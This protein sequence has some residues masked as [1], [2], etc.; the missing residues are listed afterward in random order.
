MESWLTQIT[1]YL[2]V[3]SWQIAVLTIL[4]AITSFL[5]RNRSAHVRYLLWLIVLAKCLVPPFYSVPL[6]VLPYEKSTVVVPMSPIVERTAEDKASGFTM[7]ES[8]TSKVIPS[9]A[10]SSPKATKRLPTNNIRA[11][12]AIGWFIGVGVLLFFNVLNALR[13]QAWLWRQ[14]RVLPVKVRSHIEIFFSAQGLKR[15]PNIWLL[16]GINQPFVWGLVRGSIYLPINFTNFRNRNR[17][18]NLLGHEISHIMRLDALVNSLQ[19]IAQM[20][21]WFHPFVW[22]ANRKIRTEREKCCDEMAIAHLNAPPEEYS[23][24]IVE[25]LA[26]KYEPIRPVPSLAVAGHVKNIEER[27]KTMM[28]PGKKFYKRPSLTVAITVMLI[29]VLT[30]PT[31]LVLTARAAEETT[32]SETQP[33]KS[34]HQAVAVGDLERIRSLI[35]SGANVNARDSMENTPLLLAIKM[36]RLSIVEMLISAGAD[37]N[38]K[39]AQGKVPLY[40]AKEKGYAELEKIL[41]KAAQKQRKTREESS[42]LSIHKAARAGDQEKVKEFLDQRININVKDNDGRTPLHCAS[43]EGRMELVRFLISKGADVDA[44]EDQGSF[45]Q[46]MTPLHRA[47]LRG[48]REVAAIL[49]ANG[50]YVNAENRRGGTPLHLAALQGHKAVVQLLLNSGAD[51]NAKDKEE[52][53]PVDAAQIMKKLPESKAVQEE[54]LE[55]LTKASTTQKQMKRQPSEDVSTAGSENPESTKS[56][57]EAAAEGDL[58]QV[59]RLIAEGVD[60]NSRGEREFTPLHIAAKGGQSK[61]ARFLIAHGADIMARDVSDYTPLHVTGWGKGPGIVAVAEMLIDKG[62]DVNEKDR[63]GGTPLMEAAENNHV[64]LAKLLIKKGANVDAR[65]GNGR[66]ALHRA[67]RSIRNQDVVEL[68]IA[69]GADVNVKDKDGETPADFAFD[70][71]APY[72]NKIA[73]LLVEKGAVISKLEGVYLAAYMGD[74]SKVKDYLSQ[75]KDVN[76]TNKDGK[77]PLH[78]AAMAGEKEVIEFLIANGADLNTKDHAGSTALDYAQC[79]QH[80]GIA[81]F[82]LDKGA[83]RTV[84]KGW[85]CRGSHPK[86]YAMTVDRSESHNGQASAQI[87]CTGNNAPGFGT[88]LQSFRADDYRGKRVKMTVWMKTKEV[89]K[90]QLW[91]RLDGVAKT[92][93]FDNMGDRPVQG[94]TGWNK[95]E[96]ALDVPQNTVGIYFGALVSHA[97]QVWVDDFTFAI[98]GD[99]IPATSKLTQEE[100]DVEREELERRAQRYPQK[101]VNLNFEDID[102]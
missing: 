88:L 72:S 19:V 40:L 57:H 13:T 23:E 34:L 73:K 89:N 99:Y 25:T 27:I 81:Q 43:I 51:A 66:T 53:T 11:W 29:A 83:V 12:L 84:P 95:Y 75:G 80:F 102:Q 87:S 8:A 91:M 6:A 82:L 7:T 20:V 17:W 64:T 59:K 63:W 56:I 37:V 3:Q 85:R 15:L 47:A 26:A 2:L 46:Y 44:K 39:D 90:A 77:T 1:N 14:R 38:A 10:M 62:A 16:D 94:T 41:I 35:A 21:F 74:L 22:W 61:I 78:I 68:L 71:I 28:K 67:A 32:E 96:I 97:G 9:E 69:E 18:P 79:H 4:L 76:A 36:G 31:A 50:A 52:Q 5:L 60:I 58:E 42:G 93:G 24:A 86:D 92:L 70:S 49:I 48:H 55:I 98:V 101:P 54:I 45:P 33:T 100:M 30:V 65:D